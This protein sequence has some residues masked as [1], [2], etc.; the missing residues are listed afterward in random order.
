MD[1]CMHKEK[2]F[3]CNDG[4]VNEPLVD[5]A[6]FLDVSFCG[7][8]WDSTEDCKALELPTK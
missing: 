7:I 4:R 2:D 8:N 1:I 3:T 5:M 6:G